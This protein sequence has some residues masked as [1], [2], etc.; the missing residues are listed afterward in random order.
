MENKLYII[1]YDLDRVSQKSRSNRLLKCLREELHAIPLT[2]STWL[3]CM[4]FGGAD[5]I[6]LE[7]DRAMSELADFSSGLSEGYCDRIFIAEIT[8]KVFYDNMICEEKEKT[9]LTKIFNM[10]ENVRDIL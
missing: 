10:T 3:V 9:S 8:G 6:A 4:P 2:K 5:G 1:S 7:L